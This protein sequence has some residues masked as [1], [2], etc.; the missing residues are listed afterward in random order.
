MNHLTPSQ[1]ADH[2]RGLRDDRGQAETEQHLASCR[3]CAETVRFLRRVQESAQDVAVPVDLVKTAK[4]LFVKPER[5]WTPLLRRVVARLV[6]PAVADL[7]FAEV[8]TVQPAPHHFMY[9]WNDYCMDLRLDKEPESAS[10]SLLGQIA[11]ERTPDSPVGGVP[12]T[13]TAGDRVIAETRCNAWGEF[14]IEFVP[15]RGVRVRFDVQEA[16]VSIDVPLSKLKIE[17][18]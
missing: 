12:V 2:A 7:Q 11:N 17:R 9:R 8:R 14:C 10:V 15:V 1:M 13:L 5:Q 18:L 3:K 4:A 16:E 6:R